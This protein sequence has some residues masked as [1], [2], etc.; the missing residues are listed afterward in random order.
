MFGDG[1]AKLLDD[2]VFYDKVVELEEAVKR[3]EGERETWKAAR[4]QHA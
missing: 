2:N 3:K 4:E 1:L